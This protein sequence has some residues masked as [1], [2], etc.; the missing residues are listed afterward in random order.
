MAPTATTIMSLI[1]I[2]F[3]GRIAITAMNL[4]AIR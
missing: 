4:C 1:T 3:M 2:T